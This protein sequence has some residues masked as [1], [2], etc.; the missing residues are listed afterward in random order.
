MNDARGCWYFN[1]VAKVAAEQSEGTGS[2]VIDLGCK[3][4]A[5]DSNGE[6]ITARHDSKLEAKLAVTQ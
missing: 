4:T 6:Y 5:T 2:V 1:V 3:E